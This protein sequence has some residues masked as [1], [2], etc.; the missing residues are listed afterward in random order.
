MSANTDEDA[1]L[2][3]GLLDDVFTIINMERIL[4]GDEKQVGGF[5]LVYKDGKRYEPNFADFNI[6]MNNT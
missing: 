3:R 4:V 6:G 1:K 5:D 2:K